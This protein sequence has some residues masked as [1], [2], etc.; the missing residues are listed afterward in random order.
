M[1]PAIHINSRSWLRSSSTHEPSDPP[2]RVIP[3]I[4]VFADSFG[5]HSNGLPSCP[6]PDTPLCVHES[7]T[8]RKR[9]KK[10][11]SGRAKRNGA[12]ATPFTSLNLARE[13]CL[14]QIVSDCCRTRYPETANRCKVRRSRATR[15]SLRS[16]L[17]RDCQRSKPLNYR[18]GNFGGTT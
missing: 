15:P 16:D 7:K 9:K 13:S 6:T 12:D 2:P 14:R 17:F 11:R 1:C 4:Y 10:Q 8:F 5:Q 18:L 3:F